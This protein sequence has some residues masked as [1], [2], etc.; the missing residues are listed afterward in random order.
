M[1]SIIFVIILLRSRHP[2]RRPNS[3]R[4]QPRL[5]PGAKPRRRRFGAGSVKSRVRSIGRSC[6]SRDRTDPRDDH[7]GRK[8]N[9]APPLG[10]RGSGFIIDAHGYILTAQHVVEKSKR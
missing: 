1:R 8:G 2:W 4:V 9:P 7:A 6:S 3:S 10:S 5:L